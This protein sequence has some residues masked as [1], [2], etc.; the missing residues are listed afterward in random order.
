LCGDFFIVPREGGASSTPRLLGSI[1]D[2][3][4]LLDHP[5]SRLMT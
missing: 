4:C 3:R 1:T 5:L 2:G